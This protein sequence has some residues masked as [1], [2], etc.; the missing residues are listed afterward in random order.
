M[1]TRHNALAIERLESRLPTGALFGFF[2]TEAPA[3][4]WGSSPTPNAS[5]GVGEFVRRLRSGLVNDAVDIHR[6]DSV[7]SIFDL[8]VAGEQECRWPKGTTVNPHDGDPSCISLAKSNYLTN[9]Q[10]HHSNLAHGRSLNA[11]D[12]VATTL[13]LPYRG[14]ANLNRLNPLP[15]L[16]GS[17]LVAA[18]RAPSLPDANHG[19]PS[20]YFEANEGQ[21]DARADFI[22]RT[23]GYTMF[24]SATEATISI[25]NSKSAL[26]RPSLRMQLVGA[27]RDAAAVGINPLSTRVNY[28]LGND[29]SQWHTDVPTFGG[30]RYDDVYPG[31][32]IVYYGVDC[33]SPSA[34]GQCLEYDFVVALALGRT[35]SSFPLPAPTT[36]ES[37]PPVTL[38]FEPATRNC[39]SRS[40]TS[41]KK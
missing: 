41:I 24:L 36:S 16:T 18:T 31:I 5:D 28:F 39:G 34:G 21:T 25:E 26:S 32:D 10:I 1:H 29:P 17:T 37:M 13:Q 14:S 6:N 22:A 7:A 19:T 8:A 33:G 20:V 27:N 40:R 9:T 35:K 30:V 3:V 11:Q 23:A 38:S 2:A 4:I 12:A 15:T